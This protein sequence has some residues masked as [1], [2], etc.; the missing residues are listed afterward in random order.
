MNVKDV[1]LADEVEIKSVT[2]AGLARVRNRW[3][4]Q[5]PMSIVQW[6]IFMM[7]GQLTTFRFFF[8]KSR[9]GLKNDSPNLH[10]KTTNWRILVVVVKWRHRHVQLTYWGN[11][12]LE[13]RARW[14]R[15][16]HHSRVIS[17]FIAIILYLRTHTYP[18]CLMT[19]CKKQWRECERVEPG[20]VSITVVNLRCAGS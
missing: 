3:P 9:T 14:R 4:D 16:K 8:C 6:A 17:I 19:I 7:T 12:A 1:L 18:Q 5:C 15:R 13:N 20:I 10:K 11:R 2:N